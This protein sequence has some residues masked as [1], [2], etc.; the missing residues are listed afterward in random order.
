MCEV[1]AFC[2]RAIGKTVKKMLLQRIITAAVLISLVLLGI[3]FLPQI[4]FTV[5]CVLLVAV[6]AWEYSRLIWEKEHRVSRF[7]F[8]VIALIIFILT[9]YFPS[10]FTLIIGVIWWLIAPIFLILYS[11]TQKKYFDEGISG[12]V[13]GILIFTPC[14]VSLVELRLRFGNFY[15]LYALMIVWAADIGAYFVGKNFGKGLLAPII[16][17]KKTIIGVFGGVGAAMIVAVVGGFW[18]HVSG[19]KWLYLLTLVILTVLW[20]VVGDLFESVIKRQAK[21]KDSSQILPGHG[22]VYDR[23]DSLTAALPIF[24]LGLIIINN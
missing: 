6:A 22:G 10:E 5:A 24:T 20:S 13:A 15:L 8:L 19:I 1:N 23:I 14:L 12:W 16:S 4:G 21:V 7:A 17:P 2:E 18:L 9:Q 3:F 11:R